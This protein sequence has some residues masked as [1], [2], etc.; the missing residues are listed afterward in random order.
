MLTLVSSVILVETLQNH[1][2]N[3][4]KL[5]H[6][7]SF[8]GALNYIHM[9]LSLSLY[10]YI[11]IFIH[12]VYIYIYIF[13]YTQYIYIMFTYIY[14]HIYLFMYIHH[15]IVYVYIRIDFQPSPSTKHQECSAESCAPRNTGSTFLQF[16]SRA[17]NLEN[18]WE[19]LWKIYGKPKSMGHLWKIYGKS[20]VK[21]Y[22]KNGTI[23]KINGKSTG[24]SIEH[25]NPNNIVSCWWRFSDLFMRY[26][27]R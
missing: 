14:I 11:Y 15:V 19:N 13:M 23:W 16:T 10:I 21:I 1:T 9:S 27:M 18:S 4:E 5:S 7:D 26:D 3:I 8:L 6:V 20:M 12:G 22:G 25:Q 2:P 17:M 24:K